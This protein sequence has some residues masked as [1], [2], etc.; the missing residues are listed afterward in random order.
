VVKRA[1]LFERTVGATPRAGAPL[2][3]AVARVAAAAGAS[4]D[5]VA[6][7]QLAVSEAISNAVVH[8]Y[9]HHDAPG[10]VTVLASIRAAE[11]RVLVCDEGSGMMPRPDSPGLGLGLPMIANLATSLDVR[12]GPQGDGTEVSMLF[13][14]GQTA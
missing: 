9:A 3:R 7:I 12:V 4:A 8:A 5:Q 10:P 14:V 1:V 2:R 13:P 11:L 6:S